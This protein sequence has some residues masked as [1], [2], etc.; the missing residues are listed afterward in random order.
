[1]VPCIVQ[2]GAIVE[3]IYSKM[4]R[5]IMSTK[6]ANVLLNVKQWPIP[7]CWQAEPCCSLQAD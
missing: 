7:L 5:F 2:V 4:A 6:F 1:M 3:H